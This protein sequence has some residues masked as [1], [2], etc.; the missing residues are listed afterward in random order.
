MEGTNHRGLSHFRLDIGFFDGAECTGVRA[1][2]WFVSENTTVRLN[3]HC[4]RYHRRGVEF[5]WANQ[6]V[7]LFTHMDGRETLYSYTVWS[8]HG[9]DA[10]SKTSKIWWVCICVC[11]ET[12][13]TKI[14]ITFLSPSVMICVTRIRM[15]F[16]NFKTRLCAND[17]HYQPT[18][19]P[20]YAC[21]YTCIRSRNTTTC[22]WCTE[23][24]L[25]AQTQIKRKLFH[26]NI[27][28]VGVSIAKWLAEMIAPL[29]SVA[30]ITEAIWYCVRQR[31]VT[32]ACGRTQVPRRWR[33]WIVGCILRFGIAYAN[34]E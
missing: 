22:R 32:A 5:E 17:S 2:H 23:H 9:V 33:T 12:A 19:Y 24:C 21:T 30:A 16:E 10:Q 7:T 4:K 3:V 6:M 28:N 18:F 15:F 11:Y 27:E 26:L 14:W 29:V 1:W 34:G 13:N 31:R 25:C 8:L 20:L